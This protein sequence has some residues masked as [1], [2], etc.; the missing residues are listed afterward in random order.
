MS[1]RTQPPLWQDVVGGCT[2]G[3][4]ATLVGHPMETMKA[5]L[6]MGLPAW[7]GL[8]GLYLG[9]AAPIAGNVPVWATYYASYRFAK[10]YLTPCFDE[11]SVNGQLAVGSFAGAACAVAMTPVDAIKVRAQV[12]QISTRQAFGQLYR[13]RELYRAFLPTLLRMVPS[14]AVFFLAHDTAQAY[15]FSPFVAGGLAGVAEWA[16]I[17]PVDTVKTRYTM[18]S[19][20]SL[21]TVVA[22]LSAAGGVAAFYRGLGPT[23]ARSFPANGAAFVC[24]DWTERVFRQRS[25]DR[26]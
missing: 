10:H 21:A 2:A 18:I 6:Q 20:Q 17:L 22:D 16:F 19:S 5:R 3:T 4:G 8:R 1:Q 11:G 25:T 12:K 24:I 14:S 15:G 7:P 9:V 23:L 26:R 13:Q